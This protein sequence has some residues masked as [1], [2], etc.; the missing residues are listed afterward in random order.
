M[1][2]ALAVLVHWVD[3]AADLICAVL[4]AVA[5]IHV[6]GYGTLRLETPAGGL[7]MYDVPRDAI[8]P[9]QCVAM[10]WAYEVSAGSLRPGSSAPNNRQRSN[11]KRGLPGLSSV[12]SETRNFP[13]Q[14][15]CGSARIEEAAQVTNVVVECSRRDYGDVTIALAATESS[16]CYRL[17]TSMY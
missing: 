10:S 17:H 6:P 3:E 16:S 1:C 14:R 8:G 4:F 2:R 15:T 11:A 13:L 9:G 5:D 7:L 12:L